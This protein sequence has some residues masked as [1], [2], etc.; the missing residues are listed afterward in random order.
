MGKYENILETIGLDGE[1]QSEISKS[2]FE[3]GQIRNAIVHCGGRVDR[4]L[5]ESCPWLTPNIGEKITIKHSDYLKYATAV[6]SYGV[7]IISRIREQ[8]RK[9]KEE[10]AAKDANLVGRVEVV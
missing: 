2:L 5:K 1:V 6:S 7:L 4:Q 3:L 9:E 10:Q 8:R